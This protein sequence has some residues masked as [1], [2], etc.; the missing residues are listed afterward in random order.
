[1]W[2]LSHDELWHIVTRVEAMGLLA[3]RL[4][5]REWRE[6]MDE[7]SGDVWRRVL[8]ERCGVLKSPIVGDNFDWRRAVALATQPMQTVLAVCVWE[9][10]VARVVPLVAPWSGNEAA[11]RVTLAQSNEWLLDYLYDET[12]RVRAVK[13][14][15]IR[16]HAP[17]RCSHC[18]VRGLRKQRCLN[19][20]Y[21]FY[22]RLQPG[23]TTTTGN[24]TVLL[25]L[26]CCTRFQA[27]E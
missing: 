16:R 14:S 27:E 25:H 6:A 13:R 17:V 24:E 10:A 8:M 18:R 11:C 7:Q 4:V 15:C 26:S 20:Q 19:P 22:V 2:R 3:L 21:E 1:M 9:D 12:L 5:C 23:V